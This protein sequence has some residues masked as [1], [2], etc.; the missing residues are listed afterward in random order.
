MDSNI[1]GKN[2]LGPWGATPQKM[3]PLKLLQRPANGPTEIYK[4]Y[5]EDFYTFKTP[6]L[7]SKGGEMITGGRGE[8]PDMMMR[9]LNSPKVDIVN[10]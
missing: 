1:L 10:C 3:L 8:I 6:I 7:R 9:Y 5:L 4:L 2:L